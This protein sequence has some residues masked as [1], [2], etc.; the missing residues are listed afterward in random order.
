MQILKKL[1]IR[2]QRMYHFA[3][4]RINKHVIAI[5]IDSCPRNTPVGASV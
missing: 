1:Y 5:V 3:P 4:L 2:I